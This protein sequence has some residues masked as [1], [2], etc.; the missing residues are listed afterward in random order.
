[1][2]ERA[3]GYSASRSGFVFL[4]I[5]DTLKNSINVAHLHTDKM[6]ISS[7]NVVAA[8]NT[9]KNRAYDWHSNSNYNFI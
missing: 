9:V 7:R 1:M 2:L 3:R 4:K 5:L 6:D 8:E